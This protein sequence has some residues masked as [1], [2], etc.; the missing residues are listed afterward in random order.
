MSTSLQELPAI[1]NIAERRF[2]PRIVPQSPV[3]LAVGEKTQA[4]LLNISEN[5]LLVSSHSELPRNFVSHVAIPLN[6]LPNPLQVTIRVVWSSETSMQ[7]GIQLLNL[8][9]HDREQIRRW[10]AQSFAS[11]PQPEQETPAVLAISGAQTEP[12]R[13]VVAAMAATVA[14]AVLSNST[15]STS[16]LSPPNQTSV[17]NRAVETPNPITA[18]AVVPILVPDAAPEP[19][20]V[21]VAAPVLKKT[22]SNKS[23]WGK[24]KWPVVVAALFLLGLYL[25]ESGAIADFYREHIENSEDAG[26]PP[27]PYTPTDQNIQRNLP[28]PST[29]PNNTFNVP[30]SPGNTFAPQPIESTVKPQTLAEHDLDKPPKVKEGVVPP[31]KPAPQVSVPQFRDVRIRPEPPRVPTPPAPRLPQNNSANPA[32]QNRNSTTS[33]NSVPASQVVTKSNPS[34]DNSRTESSNEQISASS[35]QPANPNPTVPGKSSLNISPYFS[36]DSAISGDAESKKSTVDPSAKIQT[37]PAPSYSHPPAATEAPRSSH[38]TNNIASFP[39]ANPSAHNAAPS[40]RN[41]AASTP[42]VAPLKA[43]SPIVQMDVPERRVVSVRLPSDSNSF[44]NLPGERILETPSATMRIQRAVRAPKAASGWLFHHDKDKQVTVGELTSRIDPQ[45]PSAQLGPNDFVR[46]RATIDEEGD[47]V[48]VKP[49]HGA[50]NLTPAVVNAIHSWRF[51][52]TLIDGKPVET[53]SDVFIQF[54]SLK[55][56]ASRQ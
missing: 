9:E 5:G 41:A 4:L 39:S 20:L 3:Y 43:R 49:I 38:P 10:G 16:V 18:P 1:P 2:Y 23:E 44:V 46:V 56:R 50:Q 48:Y 17:T 27:A 11:L 24:L 25:V 30:A 13:S 55:P 14:S 37:A 28:I 12:K 34:P 53:E 47:V 22:V 21:T 45:I 42:T 36:Q 31:L 54:H 15:S 7:A 52:P 19:I 51:Q 6:G 26:L 29:T 35:N 8:S 33:L 40:N 32:P